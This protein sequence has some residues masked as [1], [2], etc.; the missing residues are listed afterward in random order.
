MALKKV[1]KKIV[2]V[3]GES[4]LAICFGVP[5]VI[6][7]YF[8]TVSSFKCGVPQGSVLCGILLSAL[9]LLPF[10]SIFREYSF[11]VHN[12]SG[13]LQIYSIQ[14]F[15]QTAMQQFK[16]YWTPCKHHCML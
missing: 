1:W 11:L 12:S 3:F 9:Y 2:F 14:L 5:L 6:Q 4:F 7:K 15:Q 13:S 16:L 10:W 8:F